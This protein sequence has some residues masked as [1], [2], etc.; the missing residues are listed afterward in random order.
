MFWGC[1]YVLCLRGEHLK[2]KA[3]FGHDDEFFNRHR[4][5]YGRLRYDEHSRLRRVSRGGG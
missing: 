2:V 1:V 3:C 5:A 4:P